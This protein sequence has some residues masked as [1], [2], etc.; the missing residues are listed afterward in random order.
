MTHWNSQVSERNND[1]F[2]YS[3]FYQFDLWICGPHFEHRFVLGDDKK[4]G[5]LMSRSGKNGGKKKGM[6]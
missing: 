6:E 1:A 5:G 4:G 2:G 3:T